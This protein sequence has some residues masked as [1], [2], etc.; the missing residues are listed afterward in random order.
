MNVLV[1]G[2]TRFIG[3]RAVPHL[4]ARG[5]EV[6]LVHRGER[7]PVGVPGV[8]HLRGDRA[9]LGELLP[10]GGRWDAVL[11]M[12]ALRPA[13]V[14]VARAALAGRVGRLVQVGSMSVYRRWSPGPLREDAERWTCTAEEAEGTTLDTYC[15]RKAECERRGAAWADAEGVPFVAPHLGI[16]SGAGDYTGRVEPFIDGALAGRVVCAPHDLAPLVWVDDVARLLVTMVEGRGEGA[17]N[18]SLPGRR[19]LA[20]WIAALRATVRPD[21]EVDTSL[22]ATGLQDDE[23]TEVD[24][25]R[26]VRDCGFAPHPVSTALRELM[27][28]RRAAPTG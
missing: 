5:H 27:A 24:I 2:G 18:V 1:L 11:D 6:T 13:H 23:P 15:Q 9:R 22:A 25:D 28:E 12:C 10:A 8:T 7:D 26:A 16:V 3:R 4:L 20:A 17:Y 19:T 14:D 21:F